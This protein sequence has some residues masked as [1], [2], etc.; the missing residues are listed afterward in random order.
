MPTHQDRYEINLEL[1]TVAGTVFAM[2]TD[3]SH[4]E[5][6][7]ELEDDILCMVD[8][9]SIWQFQNDGKESTPKLFVFRPTAGG[10]CRQSISCCTFAPACRSDNW[11]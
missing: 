10:S 8:G 7:A 6:V 2:Q 1:V 3:L 11:H 5:D 9:H 4:C